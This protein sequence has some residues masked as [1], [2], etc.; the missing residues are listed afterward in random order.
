MIKGHEGWGPKRG[1]SD[2]SSVV[3]GVIL[4]A[5]THTHEPLQAFQAEP[6]PL[7]LTPHFRCLCASCV[8]RV[9]A[10][11]RSV[12]WRR[13]EKYGRNV[14]FRFLVCPFSPTRALRH[15]VQRFGSIFSLGSLSTCF[16]F[17]SSSLISLPFFPTASRPTC[18]SGIAGE[19]CEIGSD[20][21]MSA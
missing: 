18:A 11:T 9:E 12:E 21:G 16:L 5:V 7:P 2:G 4:P 14:S 6:R 1:R 15:V 8:E 13:E 10:K 19:F 17:S 20:S 3:Y